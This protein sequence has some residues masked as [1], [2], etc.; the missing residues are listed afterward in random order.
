METK[1]I[2]KFLKL[3]DK[4]NLEKLIDATSDLDVEEII[5]YSVLNDDVDNSTLDLILNKMEE[6]RILPD[7]MF[8]FK[9][10]S[11]GKLKQLIRNNEWSDQFKF[12]VIFSKYRSRKMKRMIK[13][14][15]NIK[16]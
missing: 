5:E 11:D 9:I 3:N 15:M 2:M 7:Q 12:N 13:D 10:L 16:Y 4:E 14:L 1:D 8:M 6:E